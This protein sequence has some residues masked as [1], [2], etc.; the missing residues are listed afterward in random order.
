[1]SPNVKN[2]LTYADGDVCR[3][4]VVVLT[5]YHLLPYELEANLAL[6]A[7]HISI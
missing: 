7:Q 3:P 4:L 2:T 6:K 1:M 5:G